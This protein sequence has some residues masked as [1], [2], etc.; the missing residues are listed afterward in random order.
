MKTEACKLYST[1]FLNVS[2][3]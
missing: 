2:A 3:K 1:D